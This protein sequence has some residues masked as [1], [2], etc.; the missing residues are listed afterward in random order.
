MS[1]Q[2][3]NTDEGVMLESTTP[4]D[5]YREGGYKRPAMV[6]RTNVLFTRE[7]MVPRQTLFISPFRGHGR[8]VRLYIYSSQGTLRM[9][10]LEVPLNE[11]P[12]PVSKHWKVSYE[13][14]DHG[15]TVVI[16]GI[17]VTGWKVEV[18]DR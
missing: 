7:F 17:D 13:T 11:V 16:E 2:I 14:T 8:G 3:Y 1:L 9:T 4:L 18:L 12:Y 5:Y 10:R 15:P 6:G